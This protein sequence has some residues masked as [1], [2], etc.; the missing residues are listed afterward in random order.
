[1]ALTDIQGRTEMNQLSVPGALVSPEWVAARVDA[2]D[3]CLVEVAGLRPEDVDAYHAGHVP[4][5][6]SWKWQ[7]TLWDSAKREFPSPADFARGM[8]AAGIDNDTTV[9]FYGEG[10]QFG[11]YAWW[12]LRYCGHKRV[13]V[14]DGA[15]AGWTAEGRPL[16]KEAPP[17][18]TPREYRPTARLERMR[19][20][21]EDVLRAL[22]APNTV[23]L[24]GRSP[25]EYRGERVGAPGGPDHGAMRY[26]RIP[27]A[28]HLHFEDLL[29]ADRRFK[30][31]AELASLAAQRG[32]TRDRNAILYCR[33]SHRATVLYFALTELLGYENVRLY[34][35]SWTEWGNVVGVPIER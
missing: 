17:P 16:V 25:E 8:G 29:T 12:V 11:I 18:R 24:D 34:D 2:P 9:I 15:R 26:G 31:A 27:G 14:L 5:A 10:M 33:L 1:V 21:R 7:E 32:A 23:I 22:G 20:L 13:H 30:P 3:V 6:Y 4:G 28:K 35:G 19:I